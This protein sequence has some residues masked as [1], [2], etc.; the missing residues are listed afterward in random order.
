MYKAAFLHPTTR[1]DKFL[2]KKSNIR[3]KSAALDMRVKKDFK[4]PEL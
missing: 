1:K 2:F 4:N 3:P